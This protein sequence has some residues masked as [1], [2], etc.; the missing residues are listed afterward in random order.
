M[1]LNGKGIRK[2]TL[3]FT[4][5]FVKHK[6]EELRDKM[7]KYT[8]EHAGMAGGLELNPIEWLHYMPKIEIDKNGWWRQSQRWRPDDSISKSEKQS[9]SS[10]LYTGKERKVGK[11][12]HRLFPQL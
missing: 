3:K 7:S 9:P 4:K 5:Y 2:K 6:E 8:R 10:K 11:C 12:L 1:G